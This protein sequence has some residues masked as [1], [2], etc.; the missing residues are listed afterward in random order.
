MYLRIYLNSVNYSLPTQLCFL[1]EILT[2][3]VL[4]QLILESVCYL[5]SQRRLVATLPIH[6]LF[7]VYVA[8][9]KPLHSKHYSEMEGSVV[10][11]HN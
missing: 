8:E 1:P 4:T 5:L 7:T 6:V 2:S 3:R 11:Q 10:N 9:G